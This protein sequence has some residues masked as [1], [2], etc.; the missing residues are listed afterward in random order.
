M[1]ERDYPALLQATDSAR[2]TLRTSES[3]LLRRMILFFRVTALPQH[4]EIT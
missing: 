3:P 4:H 2:S 1:T